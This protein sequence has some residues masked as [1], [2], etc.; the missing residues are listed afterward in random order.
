[1]PR[2]VVEK[3][4]DK[5]KSVAIPAKGVLTVGREMACSFPIRDTMVSRAHFRIESKD[6]GF[7]V[8]DLESMN[9]TI[10]NGVSA[11]TTKA[12]VGDVIKVG[13][14]VMS[15]APDQAQ[16]DPL[17][18]RTV[19]GKYHILERI[20]RGGMGTCY[21]ARQVD[22]D[23]IVAVKAI[24]PEY[25]GRRDF[26]DQFIQEARFA[27][28]LNHPNVVQIY[29]VGQEG[30][31]YFYA[32]EFV[33][34]GTVV[35]LL[36]AMPH[37]RL[38]P[39]EAIDLIVQAARALEF[40]HDRGIMHRDI[41]PE[42]MLLGERGQLKLTDLGLAQSLG[43]KLV[44]SDRS[45]VLGTPHF[46]APEIIRN[47]PFDFR[48][49]IYSLG[50]S[51]YQMLTGQLP[52]NA[53]NVTELV[54]LKLAG[55]PPPMEKHAPIPR[56]LSA[57]VYRML[58]RNP[59]ERYA[60]IGEAIADLERVRKQ[61]D[62]EN[63]WPMKLLIPA[64]AAAVVL[65]GMVLFALTRPAAPPPPPPVKPDD[66]AA[67]TMFLNADT[68]EL[69][70][71]DKNRPESIQEAIQ[72]YDEI[73]KKY[74]HTES[75]RKARKRKE[76]LE[77]RLSEV[78]SER[79]MNRAQP[80]EDPAYRAFRASLAQRPDPTAFN[81]VLTAYK[82]IASR[83][84]QT[85]GGTTCAERA[86]TIEA[87][88]GGVMELRGWFEGT[89]DKVEQS[90]SAHKFDDA[91]RYWE[92]FI[93][94]AQEKR[95]QFSIHRDPRYR[96]VHYE[97]EARKEEQNTVR[98]IEEL[99]RSRLERVDEQ[100]RNHLYDRA[101]EYLGEIE[102][103]FA[104]LPSTRVMVAE[105]RKETERRKADYRA[106]LKSEEEERRRRDLETD[107]ETFAAMGR[108]IWE[109][110]AARYQF[111][112]AR[113]TIVERRRDLFKTAEYK[114]KVAKREL[115]LQRADLFLKSFINVV[116]DKQDQYNL[117]RSVALEPLAR[118]KLTAASAD[119]LTIGG[120]LAPLEQ[121]RPHQFTS[122]VRQ[123][124]KIGDPATLL[125]LAAF[126]MEVGDFDGAR[127]TLRELSSAPRFA[128]SKDWVEFHAAALRAL[129]LEEP[130]DH[131]EVEAQKRAAVLGYL[132][133][134]AEYE[135]AL[136]VLLQLEYKLSDTKVYR[137]HR[138]SIQKQ[139][140]LIKKKLREPRK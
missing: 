109:R 39:R 104:V 86:R 122:V 25:S 57:I 49:D 1:M 92:E 13:L 51:L 93:L 103:E 23:R 64:G 138:D 94:R 99:A 46:I 16:P 71:M 53:D 42:N 59:D 121:I 26:I 89:R 24:S 83:F 36:G 115:R 124:W 70:A 44:M 37:H 74:P 117:N 3:G 123:A 61:I 126:Q 43:E 87:W 72:R 35:D 133:E 41:K 108:E 96:D 111:A 88:L 76:A 31:L 80:L 54:R 101:L 32:M 9:G 11:K 130:L 128:E 50:V 18:G 69:R 135:K 47:Q 55:E 2:L 28:K 68:F 131:P 14:T 105:K 118:G 52:F 79:E 45:T 91:L 75:A 67:L 40:A 82:E 48:S 65:A 7:L 127:A 66:S 8:V 129:D 73:L 12:H 85:K 34:S 134:A 63:R 120:K 112:L 125:A 139:L 140:Q 110:H 29:E 33:P 98:D 27:A 102:P 5:G 30:P 77:K 78:H 107:A 62:G 22:L 95:A 100:L 137:N 119:A 113:T 90:L 114:E 10:V 17:V 19:L 21:K 97:A 58:K 4:E 81:D 84:P 38:E 132:V 60:T 20:G 56:P 136:E 116:N 15:I 6:E 106:K